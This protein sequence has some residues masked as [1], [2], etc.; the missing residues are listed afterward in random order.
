MTRLLAWAATLIALAGC[1][2]EA[3]RAAVTVSGPAL[4]DSLLALFDSL[5]TIHQAVP[6]LALLGR[7]H[8]RADSVMFVEGPVVHRFTGDSL[9]RR[10]SAAHVGVRSMG[11][12]ITHRTILVLDGGHAILTGRERVRWTDQNGEHEW[13]G[14]LTI[15]VA[16]SGDRCVIRGYRM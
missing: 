15:V 12:E 9:V 7:M 14:L 16:R 6:D 11:P 1:G 8:P 3:E 5:E 10:V 13:G 4:G 2:R